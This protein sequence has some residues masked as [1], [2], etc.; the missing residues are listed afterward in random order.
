M[1]ALIHENLGR[2]L[3]TFESMEVQMKKHG[4]HPSM[5]TREKLKK[6]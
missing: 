4:S 5:D 6:I 3:K 2:D 1:R